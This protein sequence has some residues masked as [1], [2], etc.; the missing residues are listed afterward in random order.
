MKEVTG[1]E[2]IKKAM[3]KG[4]DSAEVFIKSARG[5]S[6]EAKEGKVEALEASRDF[7]IAVKVIKKNKLGF[8]FATSYEEIDKSIDEAVEGA[9]WTSVDE[10]AG[11][12][13]HAP[14]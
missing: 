13:E 3:K 11:I 7:G 1:E 4:C 5:I 14:S 12:P 8:S 9:E 10:F 2:I 6:V